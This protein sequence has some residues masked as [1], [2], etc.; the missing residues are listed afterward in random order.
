MTPEDL[1]LWKKV[2][3]GTAPIS[4]K[5]HAETIVSNERTIVRPRARFTTLDLHGMTLQQ[6]CSDTRQFIM[7]AKWAGLKYVTVITGLSGGIRR[8][9]P[10]WV[11]PMIE[12]RKV[13]AVNGGGAFKVFLKR[14][15]T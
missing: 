14:H 8:E 9:F 10:M 3:E 5:P 6:A 2:T 15:R 7:E 4:V 12:V 1:A 13:E 11:E